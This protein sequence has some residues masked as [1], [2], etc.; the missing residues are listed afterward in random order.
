MWGQDVMEARVSWVSVGG[1]FRVGA[2]PVTN[3]AHPCLFPTVADQF[4]Y[5]LALAQTWISRPDW[6]NQSAR[7][8]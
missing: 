1:A 7:P 8:L 4:M 3:V 5:P 6:T 2:E